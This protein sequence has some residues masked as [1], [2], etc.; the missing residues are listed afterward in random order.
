MDKIISDFTT[1][2]IARI[3]GLQSP[4]FGQVY[5]Q[6]L[7]IKENNDTIILMISLEGISSTFSNDEI[8]K[9]CDLIIQAAEKTKYII[10]SQLFSICKK[11]KGILLD[12]KS[13]GLFY[14]LQKINL[15]IIEKL[16]NKNNI[17]IT[18]LYS[19]LEINYNTWYSAKLPFS[20]S[21][22]IKIANRLKNIL[23]TLQ[24]EPKKVLVLDLDNTLWGGILGDDGKDKLNLSGPDKYGDAF[25]HFQQ[26]IKKLKDN[27]ILL[28]CSSKNTENIAI[29]AINTLPTMILK[30]SDFINLK[31]NWQDK[32]TNIL[33]MA[34]ELNLGLDSFVFIDDNEFERELVRKQLPEVFVPDWPK[35]PLHYVEALNKLTVFDKKI[36]S[37]ED[38][39]KTLMYKTEQQRIK[40]KEI[41]SEEDWLKSL[42]LKISIKKINESTM[43]RAVQLI[44]KTNQM[45]LSTRRLSETEYKNELLTNDGFICEAEDKFG[46]YGIISTFTII[47]N[48]EK[49]CIIDFVLS[50]RVMG[51]KIENAIIYFLEKK[52]NK[53]LLLK[54]IPTNKNQPFYEFLCSSSLKQNNN[55]FLSDLTLQQP[56]HIELII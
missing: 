54:F 50:C 23:N 42:N 11:E 34:K 39:E 55:E 40:E 45:N 43:G 46:N 4:I 56:Q 15:Q 35:S 44:N 28:C 13:D 41:L 38:N 29:D 52:Y 2:P 6:L 49:V 7:N 33:Q 9:F 17:I 48:N 27:G 14:K 5:Q 26:Q 51:R 19:D 3:L 24:Q 16:S 18:D 30:E 53:Q 22:N 37:K 8:D 12:Y 32:S 1:E 21:C 36:I 20:T 31:I 47:E 10:I 25:Q